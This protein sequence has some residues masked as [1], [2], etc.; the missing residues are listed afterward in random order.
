MMA[1]V[2]A[3]LERGWRW[4]R[5]RAQHLKLEPV[6]QYCHTHRRLEVHHIHPIE[7]S[8]GQEYDPTNLITL[9]KYDHF[10]H[11]HLGDWKRYDADIRSKCDNRWKGRQ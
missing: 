10:W 3:L 2:R 8:P 9:C 5:L 7:I 11:G 6:C 4:W 1:S